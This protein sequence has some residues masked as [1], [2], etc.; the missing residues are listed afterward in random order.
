MHS[1]ID[2]N[3]ILRFLGN[4]V[5]SAGPGAHWKVYGDAPTTPMVPR[6]R[7]G[8]LITAMGNRLDHSF[9]PPVH[10]QGEVGQ[11]NADATAA[12]A[13]FCRAVQGLPYVRL[14]GADLY[15]RIN[16]GVDRGSMLED[17]MHEMTAVGI[18]TAATA[19]T[20]WQPNLRQA[21]NAERARYRVLECWLCPTFEHCM[22]AVLGGFAII[23][24]IPWWDNYTP[25]GDGW[26]PSVGAGQWGGHAIMGYRPMLRGKSVGIA[27]MNS[28]TA[29][30]G[31]NGCCVIPERAY[32]N[33]IGG[34][35]AIRQMVTESGDLPTI[36]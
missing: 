33:A 20:L 14:S 13:E 28:W 30:W 24:G 3:G 36:N 32:S 15:A 31:I 27:H 25:D 16:G 23:S 7:W 12:V 5:P 9:L 29:G 11:C 35:W 17:A 26:L 8:D 34:W 2:H 10:D 4:L 1:I 18:G 21:G 6:S 19:G 22:S